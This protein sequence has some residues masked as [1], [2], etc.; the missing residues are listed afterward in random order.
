MP[1]TLPAFVHAV[2]NKNNAELGLTENSNCMNAAWSFY[3]S[4]PNFTLLRPVDF[5]KFLQTYFFQFPETEE[6]HYGDMLVIWSRTE[7]ADLDKK[8]QVADLDPE[9]T[10]FPHGL[11]FEHVAVYLEDGHFF[12]KPD[13]SPESRYQIGFWKDIIRPMKD[14][15]G[16]EITLHRK[17]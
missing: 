1:K 11:V 12:H 13:P 8:I 7:G 6:L 17:S 3:S 10:G 14:I 16:F 2:L 5:L 9:D 15:S 4:S